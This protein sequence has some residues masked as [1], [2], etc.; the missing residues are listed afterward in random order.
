VSRATILLSTDIV[1]GIAQSNESASVTVNTFLSFQVLIHARWF[2]GNPNLL[3]TP[4]PFLLE[5][6]CAP[7]QLVCVNTISSIACLWEEYPKLRK[8]T[9]GRVKELPPPDARSQQKLSK[10]AEAPKSGGISIK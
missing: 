9:R 3:Q 8:E 5:A 6:N 4:V 10:V 1:L 7:I 2:L